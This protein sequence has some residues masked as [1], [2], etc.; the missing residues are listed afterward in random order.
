MTRYAMVIDTK[1]C[2]GCQT[3]AVACK[4]ANDLT[5]GV[6]WNKIITSGSTQAD[7][8]GGTFPN[9]DMTYLPMAC[10]HCE[11]PACVSV[12]PT[13]ASY[14]TED[15]VVLID[16]ETCIGCKACLAACPY[17]VR[18][19]L[20]N[21]DR[22]LDFS[23]GDGLEPVHIAGTVEKCNFCYDRIQAGLNPACMDL[24]PGRARVWGDLDDPQSE[25]SKA[26]E[27]R[28]TM[29]YL[30]EFETQPSTIYLV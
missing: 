28:E 19:L 27:G 17:D 30:E 26:L 25:A 29:H 9:V 4:V 3:C 7:C 12:C 15:G 6:R 22:Y 5:V 11:E 13:G 16:Q 8:G 14:K 10:Q 1:R 18:V 21:E 24:C 23:T 20:E 2:F